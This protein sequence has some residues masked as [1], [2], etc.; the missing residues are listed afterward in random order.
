MILDDTKNRPSVVQV[1]NFDCRPA[2][3]R[4]LSAVVVTPMEEISGP[5]RRF[6]RS[7]SSTPKADHTA[8]GMGSCSIAPGKRPKRSIGT[9]KQ[10]E[11]SSMSMLG[12]PGIDLT[13]NTVEWALIH[14]QMGSFFLP[15]YGDHENKSC[16][17]T[18]SRTGF[19]RHLTESNGM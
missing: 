12:S 7:P 18:S 5:K 10:P 8:P 3:A 2:C 15:C 16:S 9:A 14:L 13:R 17:E 4:L 6:H 19:R 11:A 1:L